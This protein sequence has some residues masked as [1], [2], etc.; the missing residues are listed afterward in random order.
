MFT[1]LATLLRAWRKSARQVYPRELVELIAEARRLAR[2]TQDTAYV[3]KT[4]FG[5]RVF[6][7][8][9]MRPRWTRLGRAV[10]FATPAPT[11]TWDVQDGV[12]VITRRLTD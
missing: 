4:P 9:Y 8:A 6:S 2:D 10:V 7:G 5:L 3:V 11:R 1:K 12:V